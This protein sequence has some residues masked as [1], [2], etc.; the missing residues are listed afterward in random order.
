M[1]TAMKELTKKEQL[2]NVIETTLRKFKVAILMHDVGLSGY[3]KQ[4]PIIDSYTNEL[5][6]EV[7]IRTPLK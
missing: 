3:N 1:T 5:L 2:K 4:D 7:S 6:K